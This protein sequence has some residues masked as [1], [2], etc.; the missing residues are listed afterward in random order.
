MDGASNETRGNEIDVR[1]E[2]ES[3]DLVLKKDI[4]RLR[5]NVLLSAACCAS[6][7]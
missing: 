3:E 7:S 5:F 4:V 6:A 2:G 1:V